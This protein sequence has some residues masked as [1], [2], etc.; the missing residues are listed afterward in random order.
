MLQL[1]NVKQAPTLWKMN[2]KFLSAKKHA[3]ANAHKGWK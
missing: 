1:K 3:V 2:I